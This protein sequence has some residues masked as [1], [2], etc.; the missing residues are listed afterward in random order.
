MAGQYWDNQINPVSGCTQIS[1]ACQ[2]CYA[3]GIHDRFHGSGFYSKPFNEVT[4]RPE[5]LKKFTK[6]KVGEVVFIGNMCDLFHDDVPIEYQWAVFDEIIKRP[7]TTFLLLTKRPKNMRQA[8]NGYGH[9][10]KGGP[11]AGWPLVFPNVWLG[12]TAENQ[13]RAEERIPILLDTP[14]AHRWISC[15]PLLSD[16]DL[17]RMCRSRVGNPASAFNHGAL[18]KIDWVIV[19]GESGNKARPMH[20]D[21]AR[22]IRDQCQMAAVPF[23]FKQAGSYYDTRFQASRQEEIRWTSSFGDLN[24]YEKPNFNE[25]IARLQT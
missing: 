3:K 13:A 9:P 10:W 20:P 19:G 15:E 12:V 24:L 25:H 21:W 8:I 22:R 4:L 7:N 18:E 11:M 23:Y 14:A 16:I 2:N 5:Q 17:L 6:V 1:E